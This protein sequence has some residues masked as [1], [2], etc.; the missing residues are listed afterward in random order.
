MHTKATNQIHWLLQYVSKVNISSL[1]Y[2]YP[3]EY[4]VRTNDKQLYIYIYTYNI[5]YDLWDHLTC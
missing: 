4:I 1:I 3:F 5:T 2:S